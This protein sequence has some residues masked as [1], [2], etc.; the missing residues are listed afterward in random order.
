[1][2]V[3]ITTL[4]DFLRLGS[5]GGIVLVLAAIAAIIIN[6]SPLKD[7]YHDILSA[8]IVLQIGS[9]NIDKDFHHWINDGMMAVFFLLVSLEI[10]REAVDGQLSTKRQI[11]L[12]AI[13]AFGGLAL[14]SLIYTFMNFGDATAMRGWAIPAATD[15]AFAL[16]VI[17][18]LG[19]RVPDSLKLTLVSIA[20]IDD[21]AAIVII[22][23]FYTDSLALTP[24]IISVVLISILFLLNRK[25]INKL[26]PYM[27]IGIILWVCVLK[28]GLHATLAGVILA[29]FI[30]SK[31]NTPQ[32]KS[33]LYKL[34]HGL[35]M[36]VSFLILPIFALAN[37]GVSL[38]GLSVEMFTEPIV[39][40]IALGLFFGKQ[41]GVFTIT[42]ISV[43]LRVCTLP[44][45]ITW[46]QYYGLGLVAG[47]GFTMSLFIGGLAF[48]DDHIQ[49]LV[50]LGV[51][52]GSL[53]SGLLGFGVLRLTSKQPQTPLSKNE[54]S[55]NPSR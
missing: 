21:L 55:D 9:F 42:Y 1:M 16:G 5:A 51:I 52:S 32:D 11:A 45:D 19:N 26:S 28:S 2:N 3:S 27:A 30:P 53:L 44:K 43:I 47:I 14:P 36:W 54:H 33:P 22:A 40:G 12:P 7:L 17:T 24:L 37:A 49:T 15:I 18:L 23:V 34:E 48:E 8:S 4:R 20:I 46:S 29:F 25:G 6:N 13:A 41:I 38:K 39:L 35:H 31:S 50:R 10:K